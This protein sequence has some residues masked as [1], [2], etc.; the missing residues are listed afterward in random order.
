MNIVSFTCTEIHTAKVEKYL[1]MNEIDYY[2][3][4]LTFHVLSERSV[5]NIENNIKNF[6]KLYE[7]YDENIVYDFSLV[8]KEC[9]R[10]YFF[11]LKNK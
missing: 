7:I 6:L 4:G 8:F 3:K 1:A 10:R 11:K 9:S 5:E 2:K